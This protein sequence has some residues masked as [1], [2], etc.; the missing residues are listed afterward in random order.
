MEITA[1]YIKLKADSFLTKR[2]IFI[3]MQ[4]ILINL[5]QHIFFF[6]LILWYTPLQYSLPD[7]I[8][9]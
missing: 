3:Q 9:I 8:K 5:K 2:Y 6:R 1:N 4:I 7:R